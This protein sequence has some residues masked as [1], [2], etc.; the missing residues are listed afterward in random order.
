[1]RRA[2]DPA[3]VQCFRSDRF[4]RAEG[5]WFFATR[6]GIDFGPFTARHDGEKALA[7]YIDTQH[8]MQRL[9]SR[10]P[11]LRDEQW[12]DQSVA[13]AAREV[14]DWR[15]DRG[16]RSNALYVDREERHK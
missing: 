6:E 2:T 11:A 12:D 14:A 8:T 3:D 1:M 13:R 15:L 5:A 16:G 10:D 4:F 7:R 9:R